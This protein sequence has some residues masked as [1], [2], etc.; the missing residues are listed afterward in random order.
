MEVEQYGLDSIK[1]EFLI[2]YMKV[3]IVSTAFLIISELIFDL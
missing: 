2:I 1:I 3:F